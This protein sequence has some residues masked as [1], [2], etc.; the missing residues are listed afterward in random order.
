MN[1]L[2]ADS[3]AAGLAAPKPAGA[4]GW[5]RRRWL[6][7]VALV[8]VVQL[9]AVFA[10]GEKR[11]P[12]ARTVANVPQLTL[13]DNSSELLALDDPTLFVLPH[14]N[15][16]ASAVLRKKFVAPQP[17]FRWQEPPGELP[18][19]AENL[20][21]VFTRFMQTNPFAQSLPDFKPSAKLSEPIL[22]LPPVFADASTLHIEGE[23]AQRKLLTPENLPSWPFADVIAPSEVQVLV[24]AAG[25]VVSAVLIP[26]DNRAGAAMQYA[27]ADQRALALARAARFAPSSRLT[28]VGQMIFNW[29]T[30]PPTATNSPA[31]P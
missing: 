5:S 25:S 13:A 26:P 23:L 24:V 18:L 11:F 9:A 22:P 17:S 7:L 31:N 20:G 28:T 19:A 3:P 29:R 10:L 15:D 8:F 6:T 1:D 14:A 30:V 21:A 12:P 4:G 2:R 27:P 16:F